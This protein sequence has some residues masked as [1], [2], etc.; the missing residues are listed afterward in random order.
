MKPSTLH[1]ALGILLVL[2]F[3][4]TKQSIQATYDKQE[5][6]IDA[7]VTARLKADTTATVTR[8]GGAVRVT[9]H[10]TLSTAADDSL[11]VGGTVSFYYAAYTLTG[12]SVSASSLVATNREQTATEAGW[13]LSDTTQFHIETLVLDDSLVPGLRDGLVGVQ[14]QDECYILFTGKYGYGKNRQGTIPAKSALVYRVW[15]ESIDNE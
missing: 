3:A 9:L 5:T 14:S 10:D 1:I 7:F 2:A 12:S 15:V 11:R 13:H 8:N 6:T 4:C